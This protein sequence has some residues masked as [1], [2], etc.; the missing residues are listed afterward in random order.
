MAK[1]QVKFLRSVRL[2][3]LDD[4]GELAKGKTKL[5]P[6]SAFPQL[7]DEKFLGSRTIKAIMKKGLISI[8]TLPKE[9]EAAPKAPASPAK[10]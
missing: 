6:R 2:P 1:V 9:D 7:V 8:V 4:K 10:K 3:L 5:Y